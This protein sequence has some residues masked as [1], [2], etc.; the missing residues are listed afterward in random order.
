[1]E[2]C[3]KS[4]KKISE[5]SGNFEVDDTWQPWLNPLLTRELLHSYHLDVSNSNFRGFLWMYLLSLYSRT[6]MARTLMA[7]L[8]QLFRTHS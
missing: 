1:M 8:P 3:K 4:G 5:K 7:R 6:S 2:N